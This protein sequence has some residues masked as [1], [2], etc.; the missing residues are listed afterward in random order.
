VIDQPLKSAITDVI[1]VDDRLDEQEDL[2]GFLLVDCCCRPYFFTDYRKAY[3]AIMEGVAYRLLVNYQLRPGRNLGGHML[4]LL[5]KAL[6][7][8]P[9]VVINCSPSDV[10]VKHHCNSLEFVRK[11]IGSQEIYGEADAVREAFGSVVSR[12]SVGVG[13][14]RDDGRPAAFVI[15]GQD[16][17]ALRRIVYILN[18]LLSLD[19]IVA[20]AEPIDGSLLREHI[21]NCCE[22]ANVAIALLTPDD[23]VRSSASP[24]GNPR[25][26]QNVIFELGYAGARFGWTHTVIIHEQTVEMPSDLDGMRRLS[27][28]NSDDRLA[29]ELKQTL[30]KLGINTKIRLLS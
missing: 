30:D 13:G 3:H 24:V 26:R 6:I 2:Q 12:R 28:N 4:N 25:A 29:M 9:T 5:Q 14:A 18:V 17:G 7:E 19:V 10:N 11:V 8:V 22:K 21:E 20:K 1:V 27:L 16:D 15:H 23:I